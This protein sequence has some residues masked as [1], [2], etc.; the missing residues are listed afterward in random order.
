MNLSYVEFYNCGQEGM[1]TPGLWI[2]YQAGLP[3]PINYIIGNAF[4]HSLNYAFVG[5]NVK[6]LVM[7]GNVFHHTYGTSVSLDDAVRFDLHLC[8]WMG[9][10]CYELLS[11][12][13]AFVVAFSS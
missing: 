11:T 10:G 5:N 13:W 7:R 9:D 2:N 6:Q 4:G 1:E 8:V 12:L 3:Q